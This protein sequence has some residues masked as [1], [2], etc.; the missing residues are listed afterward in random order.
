M[1]KFIRKLL[2]T[3]NPQK[4]AIDK[5]IEEQEKQYQK[6]KE[7]FEKYFIKHTQ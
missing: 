4:T 5:Q 7:I 3:E 6:S 1:F 2:K